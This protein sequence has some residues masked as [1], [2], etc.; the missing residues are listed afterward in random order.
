MA[1][2]IG[3]YPSIVAALIEVLLDR[4]CK[5]LMHMAGLSMRQ[6]L[7]PQQCRQL[8]DLWNRTKKAV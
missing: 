7:P 4:I 6:A 8:T 1:D 5:Q 2:T 3:A